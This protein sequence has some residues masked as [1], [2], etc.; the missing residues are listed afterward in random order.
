MTFYKQRIDIFVPVDSNVRQLL[1]D[2]SL[3]LTQSRAD[4]VGVFLKKNVAVSHGDIESTVDGQ[5]DRVTIYRTLKS[6]LESGLIHKVLDDGG[7]TRYALCDTACADG[8]HH[9]DHIHFKCVN[10]DETICLDVH[11][12]AVKLPEGFTPQES[13]FLVTGTCSKCKSA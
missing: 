6:F 11:I 13:N 9:H 12:P 8:H 3:R 2:H 10:C 5:Y 1:K 7:V 4:I